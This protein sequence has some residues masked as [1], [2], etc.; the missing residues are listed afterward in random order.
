MA[1]KVLT[2]RTLKALK[3]APKGKRHEILDAVVPGLAVRV[4]DRADAKGK[5]AQ[6]S[7]ILIARFPGSS[8]G[9]PTRRKIGDYGA[10]TLEGA[11]DTARAW[12]ELI[13]R[14]IDPREQERRAR[15][16]EAVKREN[17]FG[18][19]AEE[20][21]ETH[22]KGQRKAAAVEREVR[23]ELLPLWQNK[24]ITEITQNDVRI[25][26]K[27]I[28][29]RPAPTHAHSI[30][31]HVRTIFNW[32]IGSGEIEGLAT[33]PC[34]R[35]KPKQ[36]I[37]VKN[38]R[39]RVLTDAELSAYVRAADQLSYPLGAMFKFLLLTGQRLSEV[40][41]AHWREFDLKAKV[42]TVPP[43]RFKSDSAH[44]VP[45][46]DD[47]VALLESLPR[48]NGGDF[49]F[50]TTRGKKPVNGF[51]KAKAQLD[52][53]MTVELGETP[54]FVNHDIRRTVRTRLS[55]LKVPENVA[56]MVIGHGKKGLARVYDQHT[57][58]DEMREALELWNGRL[59]SITTTPP[60]NVVVLPERVNA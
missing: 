12:L 15:E 46:T 44:L 58:L 54:D 6:I 16:A 8:K 42:W 2:D 17:T 53:L 56:E 23:R 11:R 27:A 28:V 9:H 37:G 4:T 48:Y 52:S 32:A 45:L 39:Q 5:A 22:L 57:Y 21:F 10:I 36:L 19:I 33:S 40:S 20:Y 13:R 25:L 35:L 50:T 59:R 34:D 18:A 3:P 49:L 26:I 31:N 55:G 51:S 43:E 7:F 24:P 41:N 47:M 14:G 60:D 29:R 38:K 1:K 30:Y